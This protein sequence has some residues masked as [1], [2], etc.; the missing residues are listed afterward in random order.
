MTRILEKTETLSSEEQAGTGSTASAFLLFLQ[1]ARP[2]HLTDLYATLTQIAR[3]SLISILLFGAAAKMY[4]LP[5]LRFF[6]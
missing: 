6:F 3:P 2:H 1:S 5:G 4:N